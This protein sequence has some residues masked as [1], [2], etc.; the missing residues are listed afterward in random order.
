MY[1]V[2]PLDITTP[3]GTLAA[4]P[5]TTAFPMINGTLVS[6]DIVIPSGHCGLTGIQFLQQGQEILP[7]ANMAWITGNADRLTFP[8]DRAIL[9]N[10]IQVRTY[11]TDVWAHTHN[12]RATV[13]PLGASSP[14]AQ[15]VVQL[16]PNAVLSSPILG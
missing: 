4:V 14:V 9:T 2:Y 7:Y 6:I 13:V 10:D 8:V 16:I 1:Y 15:D 3:S 12:I 11:N 5:Q